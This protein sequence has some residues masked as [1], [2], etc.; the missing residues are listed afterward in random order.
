MTK[1]QQALKSDWW[2]CKAVELQRA[3]DRDNMTGFYNGLKEM[4]GP[5][6]KGPVH[7]ISTYRMETVS[8][9]KRV[10]ARWSELFQKLLNF[11]GD[12]ETL[13]KIPQRI[14][15]TCL[16]K[17]PTMDEMARAEVPER[18]QSTWGRRNSR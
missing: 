9:S 3:A 2:E 11:H 14:T 1:A 7:L 16:D 12:I 6:K 4:W 5:K 15:K 18:W 13:D 10:V 17:I 8:D